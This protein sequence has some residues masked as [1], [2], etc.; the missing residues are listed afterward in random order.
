MHCVFI[1][2]PYHGSESNGAFTLQALQPVSFSCSATTV[3][4][5]KS[6]HSR[7]VLCL[8]HRVL[9]L[10][11]IFI[12]YQTPGRIMQA[13]RNNNISAS[14]H[15]SLSTHQC[16]DSIPSPSTHHNPSQHILLSH[17]HTTLKIYLK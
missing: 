10:L 7:I 9:H 8:D 4:S 13:S 5:H 17:L 16:A 15:T 14:G 12:N 1:A 3:R 2:T 11:S 6:E